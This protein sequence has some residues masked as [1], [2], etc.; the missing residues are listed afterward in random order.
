M[1]TPGYKVNLDKVGL[2]SADKAYGG[3]LEAYSF[4]KTSFEEWSETFRKL[5]LSKMGK[6]YFPVYRMADGEYRFVMGR[7]YNWYRK[8]LWKEIVAVSAERLRIKNPNKWKT[9]WGEEYSPS[10]MKELRKKL[11]ENIKFIAEHGILACYYN[12]NGLHAFEEYNKHLISFFKLNQIA[13]N[14]DNYVPFHFVCSILIKNGWQKFYKDRNFLIVTGSD[15]CTETLIERQLLEMGVKRVYFIRISKTAS[16][17]DVIDLSEYNIK[18]IDLVL[19]A[20]GIGSANVIRQLK[21]LKT[22]VLDIGGFVNCFINP[23][24]RL[25]GGILKLPI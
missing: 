5:I 25:H 16:M 15:E 22:V 13:F 14:R 11:I 9:S 3:Y 12:T 1:K 18:K 8:P 20:A 10:K 23:N 21:P 4:Y 24:E 17:E 7:K 2:E 6:E 19:V